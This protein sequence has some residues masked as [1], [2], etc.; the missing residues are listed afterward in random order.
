MLIED[1]FEVP[2][3]I[4]RTISGRVCEFS[5]MICYG[6]VLLKKILQGES[7]LS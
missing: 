5:V 2:F 6:Q 1:C 7:F 4:P 3:K